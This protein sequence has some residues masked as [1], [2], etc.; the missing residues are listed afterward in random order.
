MLCVVSS[1]VKNLSSFGFRDK[2]LHNYMTL[3]F[4]FEEDEI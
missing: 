3:G 2:Q 4:H 1:V